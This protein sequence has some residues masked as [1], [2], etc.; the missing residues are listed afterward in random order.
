MSRGGND[1]TRYQPIEVG[2]DRISGRPK[3]KFVLGPVR[4]GVAGGVPGEP[5]GLTIDQGRTVAALKQAAWSLVDRWRSR[6]RLRRRRSC[7]GCPVLCG[8][9]ISNDD[10]AH[11]ARPGKR[12]EVDT[13]LARQL[14]R[15]RRCGMSSCE[16]LGTAVVP[17]GG[18]LR[19]HLLT[20]LAQHREDLMLSHLV[21]GGIEPPQYVPADRRLDINGC[22]RCLQSHQHVSAVTSEPSVTFHSRTTATR[23]HPCCRYANVGCLLLRS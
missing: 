2:G 13:K 14:P 12:G 9:N 6:H 20:R 8:N 7:C 4:R 19:G 10:A 1:A 3:I 15:P 21:A 5:I 17:G 22:L 18:P 23:R 11:R 16:C